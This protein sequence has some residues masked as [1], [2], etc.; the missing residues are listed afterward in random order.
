MTI[1]RM[2]IVLLV[3]Y[4]LLVTYIEATVAL[5]G[6]LSLWITPLSTLVGF[7]FALL[8]ASQRLGCKRALGLLACVFI[9]SLAF[10]SVGVATGLVYGP[11]HYTAKLGP[12][13]LGM[14]P[15]LIPIA[16]F[17]MM[18]PSFVIA[19]RLVATRNGWRRVLAVAAL[20]SLVMTAWD[21][22]MDPVMVRGEH[23]VW[24]VNGAYFGIPLQ[25]FWGWWLTTFVTF[26]VFLLFIRSPKPSFEVSNDRLTILSYAVTGLGNTLGAFLVGLGGPALVGLF[27]MAPWVVMGWIG[28]RWSSS[29]ACSSRNVSRPTG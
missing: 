11:Y 6:N 22:V 8:H 2:L 16:W 14:V 3:L 13:F 29:S 1:R 4:A 24:E 26:V 21:L 12:L 9:V 28:T 10:E 20:G 18:Y 27:A 5:G 19:D 25:N 7:S 17:M 15:F 23:W